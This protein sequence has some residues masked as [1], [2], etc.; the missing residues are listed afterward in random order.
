[1]I[2]TL[3]SKPG[4]RP[5]SGQ[6]KVKNNVVI[7]YPYKMR[8]EKKRKKKTKLLAH[9]ELDQISPVANVVWNC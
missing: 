9:L 2:R 7:M 3:K 6:K 4:H 5:Q 8:K 1:M